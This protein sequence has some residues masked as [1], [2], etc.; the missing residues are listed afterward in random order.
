MVEALERVVTKVVCWRRIKHGVKA[1]KRPHHI[2]CFTARVI[3]T[4]RTCGFLRS[5]TFVISHKAI[6]LPMLE[7]STPVGPSTDTT[8]SIGAH[9][10]RD[11]NRHHD[12]QHS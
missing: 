3:H 1:A 12:H 9:T 8:K 2:V 4:D 11:F 5:Q 7:Y 10:E 6:V